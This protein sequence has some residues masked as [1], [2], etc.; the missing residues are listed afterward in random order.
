MPGPW[1]QRY[2]VRPSVSTAR[3][4]GPCPGDARVDPRSGE[5]ELETTPGTTADVYRQ[6]E[7]AIRAINTDIRV[8]YNDSTL[9][10]GERRRQLTALQAERAEAQRSLTRAWNETVR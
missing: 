9:D 3:D 6:A 1:A 5:P 7:R 2:T 8:V 4:A 10:A